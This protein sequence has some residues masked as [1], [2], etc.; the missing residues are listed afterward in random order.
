MSL[1][2]RNVYEVK[3]FRDKNARRVR[4]DAKYIGKEVEKDSKRM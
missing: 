2:R 1:V 4:Q 3:S